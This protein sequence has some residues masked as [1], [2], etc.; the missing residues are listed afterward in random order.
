MLGRLTHIAP[1]SHAARWTVRI[2]PDGET[3]VVRER[4]AEARWWLDLSTVVAVR[5]E[6]EGTTVADNCARDERRTA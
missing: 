5:D 4:W 1:V 2:A 3:T 6:D